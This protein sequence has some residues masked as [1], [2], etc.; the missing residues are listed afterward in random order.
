MRGYPHPYPSLTP[1]QVSG[2]NLTG[3]GFSDFHL[4]VELEWKLKYMFL[5]NYKL[6]N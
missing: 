5:E 6:I 2:K 1:G 4:C 3:T